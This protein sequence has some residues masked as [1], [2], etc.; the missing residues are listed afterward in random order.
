MKLSKRLLSK[1]IALA[2]ICATMATAAFAAP[3]GTF[4]TSEIQITGQ[5][6]R[7]VAPSYAILTLGITSQNTNINAAKSNNDRIMSDL[8][9]RLANLG[10]DKKDIF[11][12]N[13]SINPTSDYQEG[14][15]INTG[16]NVS[17]HVTVKINNLD[18]VGKVVDAAVSAGGAN[19]INN[20]SF[21]NDVSQQLSD[22]LTTE[23]IQ[24]GRHK[25]EVIA[26]ALGRTLGPVKTISIST[27]ETSSMDSGYYR[28]AV[29]L[30]ASLETT[31]PVEKGSLVV[32]Q[33]ANITYYL[34]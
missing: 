26:A 32:S 13:I 7:S 8:I 5:A 30:K 20:L 16:Y 9:S 31:T 29:M 15:R 22:S 28:N 24:N 27:T 34:Q 33:D 11:T 12:S 19:D 23:A 4:D 2:A 6:S 21:Q 1:T 14:K 17:N 25:A 18:N 10:V 3:Q